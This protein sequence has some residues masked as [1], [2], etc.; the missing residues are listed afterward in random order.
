MNVHAED[1]DSGKKSKI[2]I[3]N[4]KGRLSKEEIENLVD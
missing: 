1:K 2:T 4:D 3:K